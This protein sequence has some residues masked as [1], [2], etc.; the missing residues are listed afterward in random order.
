MRCGELISHV[1]RLTRLVAIHGAS[2][3]HVALKLYKYFKIVRFRARALRDNMFIVV[4][5]ITIIY[6]RNSH[7]PTLADDGVAVGRT[8][9]HVC[10]CLGATFLVKIEYYRT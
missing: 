2:E 3:F 7:R 8:A 1:S 9:S 10:I 5:N 4:S 6:C